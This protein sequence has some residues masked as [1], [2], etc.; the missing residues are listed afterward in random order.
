MTGQRTIAALFASATIL[1]VLSG[2][3]ESGT[4]TAPSATSTPPA[5]VT[6]PAEAPAAHTTESASAA[7]DVP[8]IEEIMEHL[9][10]GR[11]SATKQIGLALAADEPD[12][13]AIAAKMPEYIKYA[14][15]LPQNEP[16]KGPKISWDTLTAA[17]AASA[18]A[19]DEAVKAKSKPAAMAAHAAISKSCK[20]C[21]DLHKP[22]D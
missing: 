3:G 2:C 11:N 6:P 14:K 19:L 20:A 16:L 18:V 5:A 7:S 17:Y 15:A 12:W 4:P 10:A 1:F 13:D 22:K 8:S 9:N 21:H